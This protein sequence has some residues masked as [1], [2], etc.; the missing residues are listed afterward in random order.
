MKCPLY[1]EA[2][3][4]VVY[5]RDFDALVLQPL[6]IHG[7]YFIKKSLKLNALPLGDWVELVSCFPWDGP[8]IAPGLVNP[9]IIQELGLA[10][11]VFEDRIDG[12]LQGDA[13]NG[14]YTFLCK[15]LDLPIAWRITRLG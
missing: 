14:E 3:D 5:I 9:P 15:L 13:F 10:V 4:N 1:R 12:V 7:G 8:S 2:E 6:R 11:E